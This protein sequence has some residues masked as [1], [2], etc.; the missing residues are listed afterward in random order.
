MNYYETLYIVHPALESGRLK[1]IVSSIDGIF[2][3]SDL[4]VISIDVWGKKKLAYLIEKQK[5]GTYVLVQFESNGQSNGKLSFELETNPNVL[6]H[7][8]SKISETDVHRGLPSLDDQ[9]HGSRPIS[10][11]VK[12]DKKEEVQKTDSD[13]T[14][15][16]SN[17]SDQDQIAK[18]DSDANTDNKSESKEDHVDSDNDIN[19]ENSEEKNGTDE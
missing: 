4:N 9:I 14:D 1:D 12:E 2:K 18:D 11:E 5:Y 7:L 16:S 13:T 8:T 19:K 10:S 15:N 6:S 17:E 3:S